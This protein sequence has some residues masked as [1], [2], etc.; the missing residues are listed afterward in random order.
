MLLL[1]YFFL[2]FCNPSDAFFKIKRKFLQKFFGYARNA[3]IF[4]LSVIKRYLLALPH[5]NFVQKYSALCTNFSCSSTMTQKLN[6]V[7]RKYIILYSGNEKPVFSTMDIREEVQDGNIEY[8]P[9]LNW[10]RN[11]NKNI[12]LC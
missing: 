5:D 12:T 2:F 11:K 8:E 6:R 9:S 1:S 10:N 4:D 7:N 3:S